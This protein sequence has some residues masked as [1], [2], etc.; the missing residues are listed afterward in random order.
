MSPR[1]Q[2]TAVFA[3]VQLRAAGLSHV[4]EHMTDQARVTCT[5]RYADDE[6]DRHHS[7]A[8]TAPDWTKWPEVGLLVRYQ[9]TR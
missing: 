7:A 3:P 1:L 4:V 2:A 8:G 9:Y 6:N 5:I